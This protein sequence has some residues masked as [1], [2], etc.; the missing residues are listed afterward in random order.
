MRVKLSLFRKRRRRGTAKPRAEAAH[1]PEPWGRWIGL[2]R[3][4]CKGETVPPLQG[5]RAL[6]YNPG[7]RPLRSLRPGLCCIALSALMGSLSFTGIRYGTR[8]ASCKMYRL[9]RILWLQDRRDRN[10]LVPE[11]FDPFDRIA[12]VAWVTIWVIKKS[13]PP[14]SN[15]KIGFGRF[16]HVFG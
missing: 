4:P 8:P 14:V 3:K 7:P 6:L 16:R 15:G 2:L 10:E 5:F 13:G 11:S 1:R 12:Q 9:R